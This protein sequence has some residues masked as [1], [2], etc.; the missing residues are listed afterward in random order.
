MWPFPLRIGVILKPLPFHFAPP[1]TFRPLET[2]KSRQAG[3]RTRNERR[4]AEGMRRD[5]PHSGKHSLQRKVRKNARHFNVAPSLNPR[6]T[7]WI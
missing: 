7:G 5:Q 3:G 4:G 1:L 6:A 2:R